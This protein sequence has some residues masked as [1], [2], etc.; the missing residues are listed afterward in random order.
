M[1]RDVLDWEGVMVSPKVM[2]ILTWTPTGFA[3]V[4]AL[5]NRCKFNAS[6]YVSKVLTPLSE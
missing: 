6:Y 2:F 4:T 1:S 3:V 5:E